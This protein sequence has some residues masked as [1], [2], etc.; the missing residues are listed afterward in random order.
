MRTPL[1]GEPMDKTEFC[2]LLD[3]AIKDEVEGAEHYRR[4]SRFTF[5]AIPDD[6]MTPEERD[7]AAGKDMTLQSVLGDAARDEE[8][9]AVMLQFVKDIVCGK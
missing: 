4:M 5:Y 7:V 6:D 2:N 9:H 1:E 8:R 3:L